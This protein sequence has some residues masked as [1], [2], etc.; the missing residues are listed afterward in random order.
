MK[1]KR[2]RTNLAKNIGKRYLPVTLPFSMPILE[3]KL[4]C[5]NSELFVMP[6]ILSTPIKENQLIG[7]TLYSFFTNQEK[8]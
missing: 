7:K 1:T 5:D 3:S 4:F 2:P 6:N 8:N